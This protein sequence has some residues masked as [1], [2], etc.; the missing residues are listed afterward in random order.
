MDASRDTSVKEVN[1]KLEREV[2][3]SIISF[4]RGESRGGWFGYGMAALIFAAALSNMFL[5]GRIR[6]VMKAEMPKATWKKAENQGFKNANEEAANQSKTHRT[7]QQQQQQ[8]TKS[9]SDPYSELLRDLSIIQT[10][11]LRTLGLSPKDFNEKAVK[12]AYRS[13]VM[14]YHPDRIAANDPK[15]EEYLKKFQGIS[16][17]YQVLLDMLNKVPNRN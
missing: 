11:H 8:Q 17:S 15:K 4:Q 14:T 10:S 2:K 13:L 5:G 3:S 7:N 12:T 1:Q 9:E 6:N 16:H